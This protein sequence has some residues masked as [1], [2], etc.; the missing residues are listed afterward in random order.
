MQR[1]KGMVHTCCVGGAAH[2]VGPGHEGGIR[3]GYLGRDRTAMEDEV[4][5]G[6]LPGA[7]RQA[8]AFGG[9]EGVNSGIPVNLI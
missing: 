3:R 9:L 7:W 5:G 8:A 6:D 1:A 2:A 4:R